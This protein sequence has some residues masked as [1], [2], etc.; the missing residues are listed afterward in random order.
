MS[1]RNRTTVPV[2]PRRQWLRL[3]RLE[4]RAVPAILGLVWKDSLG[5]GTQNGGEVAFGGVP[6]TLYQ[7][8]GDLVFNNGGGDDILLG[9]VNSAT[10]GT[11]NF[12]VGDG[13]YYVDIDR[14]NAAVA[15]LALAVGADPAVVTIVNGADVT[16]SF[17]FRRQSPPPVTVA[18]GTQPPGA[19]PTR[20]SGAI[21]NIAP[22]SGS[23]LGG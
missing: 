16:V 1:K 10:D 11:F 19:F 18:A 6:I 7:D 8:G 15:P 22:V 5:G 12:S 13:R 21:V 4:D 3:E 23:T 14:T 17:G 2:R 20:A 9:T